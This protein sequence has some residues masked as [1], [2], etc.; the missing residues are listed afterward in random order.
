LKSVAKEKTE[1]GNGKIEV[2]VKIRLAIWMP[3]KLSDGA[4]MDSGRQKRRSRS[5]VRTTKDEVE[6]LMQHFDMDPSL[7]SKSVAIRRMDAGES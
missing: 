1:T 5:P 3:A 7:V 4:S 2:E 6:G